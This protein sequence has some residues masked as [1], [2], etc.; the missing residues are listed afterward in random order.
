MYAIYNLIIHKRVLWLCWAV[1]IYAVVILW[2]IHS[3]FQ[4]TISRDGIGGMGVWQQPITTQGLFPTPI[5]AQQW[6]FDF[7]NTEDIL[8]KVKRG[9]NDKLLLTPELVTILTRAVHALPTNMND[10]ALNRAA[11]LVFKLSP[12]VPGKQLSEVFKSY[13]QL[14]QAFIIEESSKGHIELTDKQA[15]FKATIER[16][17]RYLGIGVASKLFGKQRAITAYLYKRKAINKNVKLN[18]QQ[19]QKQRHALKIQYQNTFKPNSRTELAR[20]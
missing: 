15:I 3:D 5:T 17:N 10:K 6:H 13:Y 12:V 9:E 19:K 18:P 2:S 7:E 11:F 16:Q 8:G 14:Q 1:L 4:P 20:E